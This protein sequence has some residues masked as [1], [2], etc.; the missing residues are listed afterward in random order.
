[1]MGARPGRILA[2][3]EIPEPFPRSH[4]FRES[5]RYIQSCA[6]VSAALREGAAT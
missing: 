4:A 3:I 5:A 6:K 1:V 2:D